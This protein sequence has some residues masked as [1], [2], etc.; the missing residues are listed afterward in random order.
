M[1]SFIR[2]IIQFLPPFRTGYLFAG[3]PLANFDGVHYLEIAFHGYTNNMRFM[4]FYPLVIHIVSSA[5][6]FIPLYWVGLLVSIFFYIASCVFLYKLL[7][8]DYSKKQ[9][10]KAIV[11]LLVFPTSFC[12]DKRRGSKCYITVCDKPLTNRKLILK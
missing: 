6:F 9:S 11:A 2:F 10:I 5:L 12:F 4:P 1:E 8:L 7:R 3:F